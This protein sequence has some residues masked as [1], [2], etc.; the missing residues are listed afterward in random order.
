MLDLL[1]PAFLT[2]ANHTVV[3][4]GVVNPPLPIYV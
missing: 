2:A 1:I 3:I 4:P